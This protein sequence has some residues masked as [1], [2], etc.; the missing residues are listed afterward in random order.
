MITYKLEKPLVTHD[1]D[2]TQLKLKSPTGLYFLRH[3]VP[4]QTVHETEGEMTRFQIRYD[5]KICMAW[6]SD[7]TDIDVP[8]LEMVSAYDLN[9]LFGRIFDMLTRPASYLAAAN[10]PVQTPAT[11]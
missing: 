11:H 2:V 8:V 1:G 7:M 3:G 10:V 4:F 5:S 9:E 6:L